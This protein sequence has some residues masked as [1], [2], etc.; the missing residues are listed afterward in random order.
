MGQ[1]IFDFGRAW[2]LAQ[3]RGITTLRGLAEAAGLS[4]PTVSEWKNAGVCTE[5]TA[6]CVAFCF[7][8]SLDD[9]RCASIR[10]NA[11][12]TRSIKS[13]TKNGGVK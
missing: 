3:R 5:K 6:T 4:I 2:R 10:G 13:T 7:G 11:R 8:V 9:L 12:H 1:Q